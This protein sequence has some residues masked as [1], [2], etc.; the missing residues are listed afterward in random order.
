MN[1]H[2]IV[3]DQIPA[4]NQDRDG[5]WRRS[6]GYATAADGSRAPSYT[7]VSVRLQI[8]SLTG[9]DLRHLNMLNIQGVQRAVYMY[10]NV[11]GVVRT[12]QKGG[13]LL[14]FSQDIG[15]AVATWKVVAVLETWTPDALAWCKLGVTLQL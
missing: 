10:S 13:D 6:T 14:L 8:Q 2:A 4:V 9:R 7:D 1:L 3:R 15:G 11:Q 5:T 12:D